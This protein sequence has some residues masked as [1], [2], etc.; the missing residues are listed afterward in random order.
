[1]SKDDSFCLNPFFLDSQ[2]EKVCTIC[3][4]TPIYY[5]TRTEGKGKY[6]TRYGHVCS[7]ECFNMWLIGR[8]GSMSTIE[9]SLKH[10]NNQF[11]R[12]KKEYNEK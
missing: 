5:I 3:R 11:E 6:S 8:M 4:R 2:G 12:E 9:A 10:W 1:M 7:E